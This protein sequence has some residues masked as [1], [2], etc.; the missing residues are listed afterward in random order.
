[1][2]SFS[3]SL[4]SSS[5]SSVQNVRKTRNAREEEPGGA[6]KYQEIFH[7]NT[8][9]TESTLAPANAQGLNRILMMFD[10]A[11]RSNWVFCMER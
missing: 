4:V 5:Y 1:M 2:K 10:V 8:V 9:L 3:G 11:V 6:T 7:D